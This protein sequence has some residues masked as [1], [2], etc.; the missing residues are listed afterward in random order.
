MWE[1]EPH[2]D[3]SELYV[4]NSSPRLGEKITLRVRVPSSRKVS[5]ISVRIYQDGEPRTFPLVKSQPSTRSSA[6]DTWWEVK[7]VIV[8]PV[9]LY[10]FSMVENDSPR[11][12]AST[13]FKDY[14]PNSNT[15]FVILAKP[16]YAKWISRTVFYQ[17]FPDRFAS[18]GKSRP[19]PAWAKPR[20]WHSLPEGASKNTASEY[21]GGDF[22]GIESKIDYITDLGVRGIYLTPIFP[23]GSTHRYDATSFNHVDPLLGGDKE[24]LSFLRTARKRKIKVLTDLTTNHVGRGHEWFIKAKENKSSKEHGYFYWDKK[25]LWGYVGW[26]DLPSLPKLNFS[27]S[28]LRRALYKGPQSAFQRWLKPP[29]SLDGW[30]IDVGNMTGRY[31]SMDVHDEVVREIRAVMDEVKPDG[32]LVAENADWMPAD[33]NSFGWHGSMNYQGFTRPL[34]SWIN[35]NPNVRPGGQGFAQEI[36]VISTLQF[37]TTLREFNGSIPWRSLLASMT[38]LDSHDTARFRNIVGG[39]RG[40]HVAAMTLL[41]TYPGVPSIFAGGEIGL[42]GA[43]GEESRRTMPWDT[44]QLWDIEFLEIT[45]KLVALRSTSEA[46]AEGGLRFLKIATDHFLYAREIKA[47]SVVILVSR[48]RITESVRKQS[49]LG[50]Y[51]ISNGKLIFEDS[52]VMVWKAHG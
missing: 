40:R 44:P 13:G 7:V 49:Y 32:W 16:G 23:A 37:V 41:L 5:N 26:W 35:K 47:E 33:L 52:H 25:I 24:F 50:D 27:S 15:D 20:A 2:H 29:F 21:F 14:E 22:A 18:S 45:K 28:A 19:L 3:G 42:E 17:I 51:G 46:L 38:L 4:S 12:L 10:R 30:R 39:D 43:W 9:T 1:V 36:P 6:R 8:N 11:W 31:K 34:W 48:K